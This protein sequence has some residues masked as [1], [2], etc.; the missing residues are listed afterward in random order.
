[1][2][3]TKSVEWPKKCSCGVELSETDWESMKYV[4]IQRASAF[5]D[6]SDLELRNCANCMSTLAI[7]VVDD[8]DY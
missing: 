4:G 5:G 3:K 6:Y 8:F 7:P 2:S 1:M